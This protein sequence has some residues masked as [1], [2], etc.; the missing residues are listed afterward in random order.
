[1]LNSIIFKDLFSCFKP[2]WVI[3]DTLIFRLKKLGEWGVSQI[4]RKQIFL[5]CGQHD[6]ESLEKTWSEKVPSKKRRPLPLAL[7]WWIRARL[8][9]IIWIIACWRPERAGRRESAGAG[10]GARPNLRKIFPLFIVTLSIEA[11]THNYS[12]L[13]TLGW[14][15]ESELLWSVNRFYREKKICA[16]LG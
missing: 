14:I 9:W 2:F 4:Y 8:F 10:A 13:K 15:W 5:R 1:M 12:W 16:K 6:L 3:D 7:H 11:E